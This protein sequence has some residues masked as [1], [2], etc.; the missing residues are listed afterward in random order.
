[1]IMITSFEVNTEKLL[2]LSIKI[3]GRK[4]TKFSKVTQFFQIKIFFYLF[5]QQSIISL[6]DLFL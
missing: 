1:M 6:L 2:I 3:S 4:V 5:P